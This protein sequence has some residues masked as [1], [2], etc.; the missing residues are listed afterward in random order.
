MTRQCRAFPL[1]DFMG[2]NEDLP[3]GRNDTILTTKRK[4]DDFA[5]TAP[6]MIA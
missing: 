5:E 2:R 4:L 3:A 6:V 1:E